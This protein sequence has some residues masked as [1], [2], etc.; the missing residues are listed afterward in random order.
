MHGSVVDSVECGLVSFGGMDP[1]QL[2]VW[3]LLFPLIIPITHLYKNEVS[4][5]CSIFC[6][7]QGL[8]R[9]DNNLS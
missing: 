9:R 7:R 8:R 3:L 4:M 2:Q 1:S 5:L 6:M